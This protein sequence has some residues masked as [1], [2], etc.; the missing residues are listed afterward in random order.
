MLE[1]DESTINSG[2][3]WWINLQTWAFMVFASHITLFLFDFFSFF[4]ISS[5]QYQLW[6]YKFQFQRSAT[7]LSLVGDYSY[8]FLCLIQENQSSTSHKM[9]L[10]SQPK[11]DQVLALSK[12]CRLNP[13][14]TLC[15][16]V[17]QCCPSETGKMDKNI[18]SCWMVQKGS[19][20]DGS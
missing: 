20:I 14:Y 18:E 5:F 9:K 7:K 17:T 2:Q 10:R 11:M 19:D 6:S 4:R 13:A 3:A 16:C 8:S 1:T 15:L 12:T